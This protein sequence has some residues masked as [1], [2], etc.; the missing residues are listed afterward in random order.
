GV[1]FSIR[2]GE[3]VGLVGESGCGK[4]MVALSIMQLLPPGGSIVG[5][6]LALYC[7]DLTQLKPDAIRKVRGNEIA[8]VFQDPMT[9]LNPT[10][11]IGDQIAESY[12]AHKGASKKEGAERA[13]EVLNLVGMPRPAERL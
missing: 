3:T 10:M 1:S 5:G 6:S 13:A 2:Q 12:C 11:K 7:L 9:S 8:M 4:S